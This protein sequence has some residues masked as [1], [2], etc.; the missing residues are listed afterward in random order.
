[1]FCKY[2]TSLLI[3]LSSIAFSGF[4]D[5]ILSD[6][7]SLRG[8]D[9]KGISM[10]LAI[11]S[12][13]MTVASYYSD[14][15]AYVWTPH[16]ESNL[17]TTEGQLESKFSKR[18]ISTLNIA[19]IDV[20]DNQR[21]LIGG[22][23]Y[24]AIW[25]M[26][27]DKEVREE[28]ARL[29]GSILDVKFGPGED[30]AIVVY[31]SY[32]RGNVIERWNMKEKRVEKSINLFDSLRYIRFNN[33]K[34]KFVTSN[35]DTNDHR[36]SNVVSVFDSR[37]LEKLGAKVTS[38]HSAESVFNHA[39]DEIAIVNWGEVSIC[40]GFLHTKQEIPGSDWKTA[41]AFQG[42]SL[43]LL[44]SSL[45]ELSLVDLHDPERKHRWTLPVNNRGFAKKQFSPDGTRLL[46]WDQDGGLQWWLLPHLE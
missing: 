14:R 2:S 32:T 12:S 25:S 34:S 38:H 7:I 43:W 41:L 10:A 33:D 42:D 5:E 9:G 35:F 4:A 26:D 23:S 29:P 1:M 17:T 6:V 39:S 27:G 31:H 18:F 37:S 36:R 45:R 21:L 19:A 11:S 46:T 40:D 15:G 22:G 44:S 30:E 13:G 28:I 3:L 16:D 8:G 20:D 24:F